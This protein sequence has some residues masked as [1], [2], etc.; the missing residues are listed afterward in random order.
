MSQIYF[1]FPLLCLLDLSPLFHN[2]ILQ[3]LQRL[4]ANINKHRYGTLS[5]MVSNPI[6]IDTRGLKSKQT[7]NICSL[8]SIIVFS[9][10]PTGKL[11]GLWSTRQCKTIQNTNT[12]SQQILNY[13]NSTNMEILNCV[14]F[15]LPQRNEINAPL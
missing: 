5:D 8:S 11:N 15:C 1:T 14:F 3:I 9:F 10:P 12:K 7:D 2:V 13:N 4:W 6:L